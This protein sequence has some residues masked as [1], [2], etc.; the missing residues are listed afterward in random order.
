[1]FSQLWSLAWKAYF[2]YYLYIAF[3]G[4]KG[5]V[6]SPYPRNLADLRGG[7]EVIVLLLGVFSLAF[8]IKLLPKLIWQNLFYLFL[9]IWALDFAFALSFFNHLSAFNFW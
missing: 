4:I 9:A 6:L 3:Q 5:L 8:G 7:V 2:V 1:M